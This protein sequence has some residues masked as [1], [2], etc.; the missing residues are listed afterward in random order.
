MRIKNHSKIK[1]M[2]KVMLF[3]VFS[4]AIASYAFA[5]FDSKSVSVNTINNTD[6]DTLE[7]YWSSPFDGTFSITADVSCNPG[8]GYA[9]GEADIIID[10]ASGTDV[11][12]SYFRDYYGSGGDSDGYSGY[13]NGYYGT[14][15]AYVTKYYGISASATITISW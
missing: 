9:E 3:I 15:H 1:I 7:Y 4:I 10:V 14:V 6:S 2:K 11:E 12:A 5:T 13:V 8:S